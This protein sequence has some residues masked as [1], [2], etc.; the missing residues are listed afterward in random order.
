M[1]EPKA[2]QDSWV[3]EGT[4]STPIPTAILFDQR[5]TP[6]DKVVWMQMRA[7]MTSKSDAIKPTYDYLTETCDVSRSAFARTIKALRLTGWMGVRRLSTK[8]YIEGNQ[9]ALYD[10]DQTDAIMIKPDAQAFVAECQLV[11][12]RIGALAASVAARFNMPVI[13][14]VLPVQVDKT[15]SSKFVPPANLGSSKLELP[16]NSSSSN[17][18]PS[19]FRGSNKMLLPENQQLT[20]GSKLLPPRTR[21]VVSSSSTTTTADVRAT[22]AYVWP[23]DFSERSQS[24]ALN[25][26]ALLSQEVA[27]QVLDELAAQLP[28]GLIKNATVYL[29]AL[30]ARALDGTFE[31]T[32]AG[33]RIARARHNLTNQPSGSSTMPGP[34]KLV[35]PVS[36]ITRS[37]WNATLQQLREEL[38]A[39]NVTAWLHPLML[40]EQPDELILFASNDHVLSAVRETFMPRLHELFTGCHPH[41]RKVSTRIGDG[42][43]F[44]GVA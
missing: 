24:A 16:V 7:S 17:L 37:A 34:Q 5:L 35:Q 23:R 33:E 21:D 4:W 13:N 42:Q 26:L 18:E 43:D 10:I 32:D 28:R 27:Q 8:D 29:R 44:G 40:R 3:F 14:L 19:H 41:L 38:G 22:R 36:Q 11:P 39:D 15:G 1:T 12:G 25:N 9:Y 2:K 31:Y 20:G 6:G 30:I